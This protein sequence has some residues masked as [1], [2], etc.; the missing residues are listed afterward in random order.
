MTDIAKK[1][2]HSTAAATGLVDR[3]EKLGY[4]GRLHAQDDRRKVLVFITKKGQDIILECER[5]IELQSE[6]EPTPTPVLRTAPKQPSPS[7]RELFAQLLLLQPAV[8]PAH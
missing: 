2:G 4:V 5:A 6:P 1:M 8:V 3:M 7:F